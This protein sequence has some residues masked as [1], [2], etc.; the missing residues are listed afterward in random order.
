[1][2]DATKPNNAWSRATGVSPRSPDREPPGIGG[3]ISLDSGRT[4]AQV[5]GLEELGRVKK[6]VGGRDEG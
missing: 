6:P 3:V 5:D 4:M 1:M 2:L